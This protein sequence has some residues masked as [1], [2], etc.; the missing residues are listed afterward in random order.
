VAASDCARLA[1]VR[2]QA[3]ARDRA[4]AAA[5]PWMAARGG[6]RDRQVGFLA[7]RVH[8]LPALYKGLKI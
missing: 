2:Q 6:P 3:G 8:D 7:G 1:A 4:C 5:A